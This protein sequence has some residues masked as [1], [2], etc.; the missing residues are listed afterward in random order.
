MIPIDQ[1]TEETI[2]ERYESLSDE[3]MSVLDDPSTEKIVVSVC[4]DHSL[5]E[6]DRV[7]AVKQITG[8]VILG[9]VHSYDLGR[10]VNDAL[11]LNNPKLAASIAEAI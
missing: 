9:F 2:L 7:E 11:N 3:L 8:L 10:E 6:A 5:L 4:R 1:L